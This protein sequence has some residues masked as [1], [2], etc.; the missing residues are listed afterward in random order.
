MIKTG[1]II[2]GNGEIRK[3]IDVNYEEGYCIALLLHDQDYDYTLSDY[4]DGDNLADF[5][6]LADI[7]EE[8]K[9]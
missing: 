6:M 9:R 7:Y 5:I 2:E 4:A 8:V 3:I 1:D